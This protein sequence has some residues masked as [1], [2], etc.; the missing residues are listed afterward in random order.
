MQLAINFSN[1]AAELLAAG[2]IRLD[3][4]KTPDWPDMI[5]A[6]S[7]FL[8][9]AVHFGIN[10]GADD[11]FTTDWAQADRIAHETHTKLINVHLAPRAKDFPDPD[12]RAVANRLITDVCKAAAFFGPDRVMAENIPLGNPEENFAPACVDPV[13]IAEVLAE[14]GAGLL[15]DISHARLSAMHL[16]IDE[17]DYLES[18]PVERIREMHVTGLQTVDGR[19]RDHMPFTPADWEI[20]RWAFDRI[21]AGDWATPDIVAFEYGGVGGKFEWRTDRAAIAE[22]VPILYDLVHRRD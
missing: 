14:S 7:K 4:F 11:S 8:P 17:R 3:R 21:A 22:Q 13:V 6:A 10:V 20:T 1:A 19:L 2:K 15:L 16:G 5:S 18:L 9:V 12:P